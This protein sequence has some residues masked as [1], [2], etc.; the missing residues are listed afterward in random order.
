[1]GDIVAAVSERSAAGVAGATAAIVGKAVGAVVV[2]DSV[3][4][5]VGWRNIAVGCSGAYLMER[6]RLFETKQARQSERHVVRSW[7]VCISFRSLSLSLSL[8]YV[9]ASR[10]DRLERSRCAT[11]R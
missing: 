9:P 6:L 2:F 4:T 3:A 11:E 10:V 8:C 5:L 1:M 7:Q